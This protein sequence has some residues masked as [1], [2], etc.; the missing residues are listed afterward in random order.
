MQDLRT[1][2]VGSWDLSYMTMIRV[3]LMANRQVLASS[4]LGPKK[5]SALLGSREEN[6]TIKIP[7]THHPTV[8]PRKLLQLWWRLAKFFCKC[9]QKISP[10]SIEK[11]LIHSYL[12]LEDKM[13]VWIAFKVDR[14]E[15]ICCFIYS[16]ILDIWNLWNFTIFCS[17]FNPVGNFY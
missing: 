7:S 4:I 2:Y 10:K 12:Q 14:I 13:L 8:I 17:K 5:T 11:R 9:S 1:F 6:C 15:R 3:V 16:E